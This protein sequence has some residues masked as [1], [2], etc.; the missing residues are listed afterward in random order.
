MKVYESTSCSHLIKVIKRTKHSL[1]CSKKNNTNTPPD[2][3]AAHDPNVSRSVHILHVA[4]HGQ[5]HAHITVTLGA[6]ITGPAHADG[7]T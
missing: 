7:V 6:I 4:C 1:V 2:L 5:N 3:R